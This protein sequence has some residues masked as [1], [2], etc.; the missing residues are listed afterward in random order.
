MRQAWLVGILALLAGRAWAEPPLRWIHR[1][2]HLVVDDKWILDP[3][4]GALTPARYPEAPRERWFAGSPSGEREA[5]FTG[6]ETGGTFRVGPAGGPLGAAVKLPRLLSRARAPDGSRWTAFWASE[7]VM[8]LREASSPHQQEVACRAFDVL[9][10]RWSPAACPEGDFNV[11]WRIDP[12]PDGWLAVYSAGE[13]HPG[14]LFARYDVK[15]GQGKA[16]GP[17]VDEYPFGPVEAVFTLDGRQLLLAT[18]CR[19]ERKEPRPCEEVP[20]ENALWR[21]YAW[22][23]ADGTLVLRRE[24]LPAD[25]VPSPTGQRFAWREPGRVCVA[26]LQG[27]AAD[28]RCHPLPKP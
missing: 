8:V 22:S 15:R 13:G 5:M 1:G 17:E 20:E 27:R 14:V 7:R 4:R 28:A 2:Q 18:P 10:R 26:P 23:F 9:T 25:V 21:L 16:G 6:S 3:E 24:G 12:G 11:V 19:L